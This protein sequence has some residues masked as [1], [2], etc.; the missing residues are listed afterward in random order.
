[1]FLDASHL[2]W[3]QQ[4]GQILARDDEHP[5]ATIFP[6]LPSEQVRSM[7]VRPPS[8]ACTTN[9][10][11]GDAMSQ[12]SGGD[13]AL[14]NLVLKTTVSR[15][16]DYLEIL[17]SAAQCDL[18]SSDSNQT[19]SD[20]SDRR[21]HMGN[22]TQTYNNA[23]PNDD[24]SARSLWVV[25]FA[26]EH[27]TD[28]WKCCPYVNSGLLSVEEANILVDSFFENMLP[29]APILDDFFQDHSNHGLLVKHE[30]FLCCVIITISS[31]Y[32]YFPAAG[33]RDRSKVVHASLWDSCQKYLLQLMLGQE[34]SPSSNIRTVDSIAALLLLIEWHPLTSD[35]DSPSSGCTALS[36]SSIPQN[37]SEN[38]SGPTNASKWLKTIINSSRQSHR[39]AGMV[40]GCA[41]SLAKELGV[42]HAGAERL[43]AGSMHGEQYIQK[44][45][46]AL[47]KLMYIYQQHTSA[48]MGTT[49]QA[50]PSVANLSFSGANDP[51]IFVSPK[52]REWNTFIA[53]RVELAKIINSS[54]DLIL[55]SPP[56]IRELIQSGRYANVLDQFNESL[57]SWKRKSFDGNVMSNH[58]QE[59]LNIEYHTIRV[60]TLSLALQAVID[61][62]LA[63]TAPA[64]RVTHFYMTDMDKRFTEEV[65]DG[66]LEIFRIIIRLAEDHHLAFAPESILVRL[67]MACILLMKALGLGVKKSKFDESLDTFN[68]V[69]DGLRKDRPD[70]TQLGQQYASLLGICVRTLRTRYSPPG[71]PIPD[72][73]ENTSDYLEESI[74]SFFAVDLALSQNWN[75]EFDFG[76]LDGLTIPT[77]EQSERSGEAGG[78]SNLNDSQ[79]NFWLKMAPEWFKFYL[80][81]AVGG[82]TPTAEDLFYNYAVIHAS[83][84]LAT[85]AP[86]E[87]FVRYAQ[88][89]GNPD[90][91][92]EA[93]FIPRHPTIRF[94]ILTDHWSNTW[95]NVEQSIEDESHR[96]RMGR[97]HF[98]DP[99][100]IRSFFGRGGPVYRSPEFRHP[101]GLT[102]SHWLGIDDKS[103]RSEAIAKLAAH[104]ALMVKCLTEFGKSVKYTVDVCDDELASRLEQGTFKAFPWRGYFA[105]EM[106]HFTSKDDGFKFTEVYMKELK[107]SYAGFINPETSHSV[108]ATERIVLDF[109]DDNPST[110]M[111]LPA[112]F[113]D[114]NSCEYKVQHNDWQIFLPTFDLLEGTKWSSHQTFVDREEGS[115][116]K[117]LDPD[118]SWTK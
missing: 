7:A 49:T 118:G 39:M 84:M 64:T 94:R 70:D 91:P 89:Y 9:A 42:F 112:Y 27:V 74:S 36:S 38:P 28:I 77:L 69:I 97:H 87:N 75:S 14:M 59:I 10:M 79:Y 60:G 22:S 16:N 20:P 34:V 44:R 114:K 93:R 6:T 1:M 86:I 66:C 80:L 88:N 52:D 45:R 101:A 48:R 21:W 67:T 100:T 68:Q 116:S 53:A 92:N 65:V 63:E 105:I 41:M 115:A 113:V 111:P 2:V 117:A 82:T 103:S 104:K 110:K 30:P 61:R 23:L 29:H 51:N 54:L 108:Y 12:G 19:Q 25:S 43:L 102:I 57:C 26:S 24:C 83:L 15:C 58:Y 73:P 8:Q 96:H 95:N 50:F 31:R 33:G 3:N 56:V 71:D 72:E 107:A 40:L 81:G 78:N 76:W 37:S 17:S 106:L 11:S 109:T 13:E 4:S 35:P 90:V 5:E 99:T 85:R 55:P 18:S 98:G 47:A 62:T 46:V 32:H